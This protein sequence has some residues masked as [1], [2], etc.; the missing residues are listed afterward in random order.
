MRLCTLLILFVLWHPF[1]ISMEQDSAGA[2]TIQCGTAIHTVP[3]AIADLS[4]EWKQF[5]ERNS[6]GVFHDPSD[7]PA[8]EF[9]R[10]LQLCDELS[11]NRI[12]QENEL[13]PYTIEQITTFLILSFNLEIT[14]LKNM[15]IEEFFH[16]MNEHEEAITDFICNDMNH[17]SI[18]TALQREMVRY[19]IK[20]Y[21]LAKYIFPF[22]D[23][24]IQETVIPRK[25]FHLPKKSAAENEL[26]SFALNRAA[27]AL[28]IYDKTLKTTIFLSGHT[29]EAITG[30]YL[31]PTD[32][33]IYASCS[34]E[35]IVIW[36]ISR[37]TSIT[38]K[39][40]AAHPLV[41]WHPHD[42]HILA[43]NTNSTIK[44]FNCN[45]QRIVQT[46]SAPF[47]NLIKMVWHRNDPRVIALIA[48]VEL[49]DTKTYSLYFINTF[50]PTV[51][52]R[53]VLKQ[54]SYMHAQWDSAR[55]E[56]FLLMT[57]EK[58][59]DFDASPLFQDMELLNTLTLQ[60]ALFVWLLHADKIPHDRLQRSKTL[61][62]LSRS[63]PDPVKNIIFDKYTL[64]WTGA[65]SMITVF[66]SIKQK[67]G[68]VHSWLLA[69]DA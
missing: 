55:K 56:H 42:P 65:L 63:L 66:E 47:T 13:A 29:K 44:I 32:P 48:E 31:H 16:R 30:F 36:N 17:I 2:L 61:P 50:L 25:N 67:L 12:D 23:N 53:T 9:E 60:Q 69:H 26:Y 14:R 49:G 51:P 3:E 21:N 54:D 64:Y 20:H 58:V 15:L 52:H 22:P 35:T 4:P 68:C 19:M 38:I 46:L 59:K 41:T 45:T 24:Q 34:E 62:E 6:T 10:F 37:K 5:F 8:E 40:K 28:E 43:Y 39:T 57:D 27:N 1:T 7:T 18:P 11:R 33:D